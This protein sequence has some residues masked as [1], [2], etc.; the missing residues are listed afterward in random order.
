MKKQPVTLLVLAAGMGSRY[1]GLKQLDA[2][3]PGGETLMDYSVFDAVRAGF[4]RIVFVIRRDFEEIFREKAAKK[5]ASHTDVSFAFQSL[6]DLPSGYSVPAGRVKPWGTG[7]AV[8]AA[9]NVISEPF[10]VINADDFYG[11]TSFRRLAEELGTFEPGKLSCC[12]CGYRLENTLSPNGSVSRGI[13]ETEDGFLVSVTE[14]TKLTGD[15]KRIRSD[16]DNGE[17]VFFPPEKPVS[18]NCWGFSPEIFPE[19]EKMFS[20]FLETRGQELKSEFYIPFAADELIR[21]G[22][23]RCK[24]LVSP[25]RWFGVTYQED[26]SGVV[27]GLQDLISS[28]RYPAQLFGKE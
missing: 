12:M 28:G 3:G 15:G 8:Y 17:A 1:G 26:R 10:A 23:T 24:M 21:K 4:D 20:A 19:L 25:D 16:L 13:C 22:K 7:Q 27:R 14:H 6:D 2:F 18:M 5:Y 9:R 11:E